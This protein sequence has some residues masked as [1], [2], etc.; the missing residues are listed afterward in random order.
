MTKYLAL[1]F[2]FLPLSIVSA[3]DKNFVLYLYCQ[4]IFDRHLIFRENA[5]TVEESYIGFD[6]SRGIIRIETISHMIK[7]RRVNNV[8][9][10]N[11]INPKRHLNF[12]LNLD[13]LEL[14]FDG[15]SENYQLCLPLESEINY[16]RSLKLEIEAAEQRLKIY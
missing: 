3:S 16:Q 15:D 2:I 14:S 6:M 9:W 10:T 5:D 1:I 13:S 8:T 7:E 12:E 11:T 4:G